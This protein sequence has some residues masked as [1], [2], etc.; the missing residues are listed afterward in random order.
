[1]GGLGEGEG[2]QIV[3]DWWM[4]GGIGVIDVGETAVV[5]VGETALPGR[6]FFRRGVVALQKP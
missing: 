4:E 6:R 3:G 5:H 1:M 2:A